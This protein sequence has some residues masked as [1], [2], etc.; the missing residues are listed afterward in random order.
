[1]RQA[2]LLAIAVLL[3]ACATR[4]VLI[5]KS[6]A[7]PNGLD[8]SGEWQLSADA[9]GTNRDLADGDYD[10]A[11]G[12]AELLGEPSRQRSRRDQRAL[13]HVFLETGSR[14]RITQTDAGLFISF[15]RAVVEEYRF[16]EHRPVNVGPVVAER[17]S[18]WEE[19]GYVIETLDR[20]GG[21]LVE[22][23]SLFPNDRRLVRR[24]TIYD[25]D[26]IETS[27]TQRFEKL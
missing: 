23:Y 20:E 3:A 25:G 27:V 1:M 9:A 13:V 19:D 26:D 16:G 11:G 21:K 4:E 6:A 7:V 10:A 15:D 22:R 18:G 12:L 24:I 17:V 2:I 8:L 5:P 14:L